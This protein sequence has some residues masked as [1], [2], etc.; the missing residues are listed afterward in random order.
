MAPGG[1]GVPGFLLWLMVTAVKRLAV[2]AALYPSALAVGGMLGV[3]GLKGEM[4]KVI[5]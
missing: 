5:A 3:D 2:A 4:D 1:P